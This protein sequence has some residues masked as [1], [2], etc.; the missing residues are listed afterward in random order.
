MVVLSASF[1]R[2]GR[3]GGDKRGNAAARRARK[4]FLLATFG[5]GTICPCA[6]SGCTVMLT[7]ETVEADRIIAGDSYRRESVIPACR[8]CNVKRLDKSLWSYDPKLARRLIRRG[9]IVSTRSAAAA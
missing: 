5:N 6:Y 8:E 1:E 9:Y 2:G 3:P 7:F 4:R